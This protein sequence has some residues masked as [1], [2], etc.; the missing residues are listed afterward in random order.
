MTAKN[1]DP[2]RLFDAQIASVFLGTMY[3]PIS[4]KI[5]KERFPLSLV[6]KKEQVIANRCLELLVYAR[7]GRAVAIGW[8]N[9]DKY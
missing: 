4:F 3:S 8:A 2:C 6:C 9:G 1:L 7:K 5:E